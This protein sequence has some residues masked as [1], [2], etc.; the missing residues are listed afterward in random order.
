[1][2]EFTSVLLPLWLETYD[3]N[4]SAIHAPLYH[5]K[6][7]TNPHENKFLLKYWLLNGNL[8]FKC[9]TV[10]TLW[11]MSFLTTKTIKHSS[12]IILYI[13][14]QYPKK[15]MTLNVKLE[16]VWNQLV[17][18]QLLV[19]PIIWFNLTAFLCQAMTD[20]NQILTFSLCFK[21][22]W[23]LWWSVVYVCCNL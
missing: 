6:S 16:F 13:E 4:Q 17:F 23:C 19:N 18:T 5:M 3:F 9:R 11:H 8:M 10:F 7:G 14:N 21:T 12:H 22:L 2:R 1:M 15:S 20:F